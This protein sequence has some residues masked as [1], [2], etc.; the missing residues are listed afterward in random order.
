MLWR[1]LTRLSNTSYYLSSHAY[2]PIILRDFCGSALTQIHR[3]CLALRCCNVLYKCEYVIIRFS[4]LIGSHSCMSNTSLKSR[5]IALWKPKNVWAA[6]REIM[7]FLSISKCFFDNACN[8]LVYCS[9]GDLSKSSIPVQHEHLISIGGCC[10]S[11]KNFF[12]PT[13]GRLLCSGSWC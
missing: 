5:V 13:K 1:N 4:Y 7:V 3:Y 8:F 9:A 11:A 10:V 2:H 12:H 6:L